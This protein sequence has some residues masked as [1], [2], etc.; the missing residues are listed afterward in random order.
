[1]VIVTIV[2]VSGL[3]NGSNLDPVWDFYWQVVES[4]IAIIMVSLTAF[5]SFFVQER[6]RRSQPKKSWY[7]GVKQAWS[8]RSTGASEDSA[9]E[10]PP[11]ARGHLT[12][13]RTYIYGNG[14]T[15]QGAGTY[16]QDEDEDAEWGQPVTQRP[17]PSN[18]ISV[19]QD[20]IVHTETVNL[21]PHYLFCNWLTR[22]R[23]LKLRT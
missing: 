18:T 12:G 8:S 4:S 6:I 14:R 3:R 2:R 13:L 10:L 23:S 17:I 15:S 19:R 5:R 16:L 1:M 20:V 7:H 21:T 9:H 11:I 22:I